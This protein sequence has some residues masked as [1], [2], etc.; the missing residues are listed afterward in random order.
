MCMSGFL[1]VCMCTICVPGALGSQKGEMD[2]LELELWMVV[3][4]H[5]GAGN[6]TQVLKDH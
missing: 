2:P 5:V 4:H 1:H 6:R 3:N